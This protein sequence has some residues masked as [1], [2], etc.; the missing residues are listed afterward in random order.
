MSRELPWLPLLLQTSDALFPTG[1]YAHSLG[2]EEIVR[3]GVV[4]D[5]S[6][7]ARYLTDQI[8]PALAHHELP[9]LRYAAA[10]AQED[11]I[12]L[13]CALDREIDAW[14]VARETRDAS[15]QIG[16][17][18]LRTLQVISRAS[19]LESFD[20]AVQNRQAVGHHLVVYGLQAVVHQTPILAVLH[21]YLYLSFAAVCGAALK[22][23]RIGQEG[24]Q[25]ALEV[26]NGSALEIVERSLNV[27]R[28]DA[29]W[30]NPLLEIAS[31]RHERANERLFIS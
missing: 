29:G 7:L 9:Y 12:D 25:R 6:S 11:D 22:V 4:T 26:A 28:R 18:R 5:E 20:A 1:A 16:T 2:F 23:I 14:K 24:C 8:S 21:A 27:D 15:I 10:A 3:L 31:M 19:L 30:F 17:R 13:L